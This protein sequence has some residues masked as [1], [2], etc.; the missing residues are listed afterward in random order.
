[1]ARSRQVA[2]GHTAKHCQ[3][4]QQNVVPLAPAP[5]SAVA[6]TARWTAAASNGSRSGPLG[7]LPSARFGPLAPATSGCSVHGTL[8]RRHQAAPGQD[9]WVLLARVGRSYHPHHQRWHPRHAVQRSIERLQISTISA[10]PKSARWQRHRSMNRTLSS[11]RSSSRMLRSI[12]TGTRLR[13]TGRPKLTCGN[14]LSNR[15]ETPVLAYQ[16]YYHPAATARSA[17]LSRSGSSS[18]APSRQRR[19][20]S[21]T[22][23]PHA[24]AS[25]LVGSG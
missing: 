25:A 14:K 4:T 10:L 21:P 3:T 17:A 18:V 2:P 9:H 11:S 16:S 8:W 22:L 24:A 12:C 1:V 5:A 19:Q 20:P 13:A 15:P 7:A 23:Q 6:S